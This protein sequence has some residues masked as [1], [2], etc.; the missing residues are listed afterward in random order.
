MRLTSGPADAGT[1]I[2]HWSVLAHGQFEMCLF[3]CKTSANKRRTCVR[4][5]NFNLSA[6]KSKMKVDI[7]TFSRRS[8]GKA[9]TLEEL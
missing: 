8:R 9:L 2:G 6:A 5:A 3:L 7:Q 4:N 1:R